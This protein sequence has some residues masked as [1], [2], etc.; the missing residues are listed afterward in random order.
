MAESSQKSRS[1]AQWPS[2]LIIACIRCYQL[3]VSP[4]LGNHCRFTPTCSSYA[5]EAYQ[6][7]GFFKGSW[8]SIK[9]LVRCNPWCKGGYDDLP[10]KRC[11]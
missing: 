7:Y 8:L 6:H 11:D 3:L 4:Y 2:L 10:H 1:I 9:R 5:A